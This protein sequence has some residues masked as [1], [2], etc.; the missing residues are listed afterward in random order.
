MPIKKT[1]KTVKKIEV[2]AEEPVEEK[3]V[4]EK[5]S[6][7][8]LA[9]ADFSSDAPVNIAEI[10]ALLGSAPL[11]VVEGKIDYQVVYIK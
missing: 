9:K 1:T 2:K 11:P 3:V 10:D 6:E 4:L 5:A 7:E 8:M